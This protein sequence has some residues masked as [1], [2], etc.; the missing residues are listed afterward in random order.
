MSDGAVRT[1]AASG[2]FS[3]MESGS[4]PALEV[5]RAEND[6]WTV[7][8]YGEL[9]YRKDVACPASLILDCLPENG[10]FDLWN[11]CEGIYTAIIHDKRHK[12]VHFATDRMGLRLLYVWQTSG[13]LLW[14]TQPSAF[15]NL[16]GFPAEVDHTALM[17]YFRLD[18]LPSD[19]T[20]LKNV[21]LLPA[22]TVR[23]YDLPSEA[24]TDTVYWS[25]PGYADTGS[26]DSPYHPG[27]FQPNLREAAEHLAMLFRRS[28]LERATAGKDPYGHSWRVGLP[29]SGGLDS[30][31]ILSAL[32]PFLA[33]SGHSSSKTSDPSPVDPYATSGVQSNPVSTDS[34]STEGWPE[35]SGSGGLYTY[36][37]GKAGSP[38]VETARILAQRIGSEHEFIP[39]HEQNWLKPR[40]KSVASTGGMLN[41]L[42]MHGVEALDSCAKKITLQLNGGCQQFIRGAASGANATHELTRLRKF[43]RLATVLDDQVLLTRLP[44]YDYAIIDFLQTLPGT[45]V[46]CDRL[47]KQ[48]LLDHFPAL[49][50][51]IPD[52]NT[53]ISLDSKWPKFR[54]FLFRALR[55][56]GLTNRQFHNYPVWIRSQQD[57][58]HH[59]LQDKDA[60]LPDLGF[61]SRIAGL[62][63]R[64]FSQRRDRLSP[65]A[66]EALCRLLT[67]EVYLRH[68]E[69]HPVSS[70]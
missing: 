45:L 33:Q 2:P 1:L 40:L 63:E 41:I 29:L 46:S 64:V 50:R 13:A 31:A 53:G 12:K 23:T 18:F 39:I 21:V 55:R 61:A 24:V 8:F 66:C 27:V 7:L 62:M 68:L 5:S 51:G 57:V 52:A 60:L 35:I 4:H 25:W 19:R 48:M 67:V 65:E 56:T 10:P 15:V 44:F 59:Y 26:A 36:T 14:S 30:R 32:D 34:I 6:A 38:D 28:V 47:Y 70:G 22:G 37:F 43:Q 69:G 54:Y 17:D 16:T 20:L 58:F 3:A 42:H 9:Y 49:F 11:D